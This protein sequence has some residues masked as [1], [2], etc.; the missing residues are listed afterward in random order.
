MPEARVEGHA[1]EV[2][3]IG[4]AR[5]DRVQRFI[6]LAIDGNLAGIVGEEGAEGGAPGAGAENENVRFVGEGGHV[7][8]IFHR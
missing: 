1:G 7:R 6:I 5:I 8:L 3:R 4:V 2:V